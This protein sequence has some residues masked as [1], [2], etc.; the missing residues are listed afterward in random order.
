MGEITEKELKSGRYPY[1]KS[2][3]MIGRYGIESRLE[4]FLT[5]KRG[6]KQVEV[7][8][9]GRQLNVIFTRHP[10]PGKDIYLTI[11][12]TL[13]TRAEELLKGKRGAV[14]ALDPQNGEVL[15]IASSPSF[16]PNEFIKGI[17]N[18]RW[19]QLNDARHAPLQNRAISGLYPPGSVFKIVV[20]LAGLQEGVINPNDEILCSGTYVM[21]DTS[22]GCWKKGGH[23]KVSLHRALV[24][25]CDI[26]FYKMGRELGVDRIARYARQF[27]FGK[28][29]GIDLDYE[30]SGLIPDTRW[31]MKR[32]GM[33]WHPGETLSMA[34]GQSYTLVTP[35]QM[36][37]FISSIFNGGILYKPHV[38]KY[39]GN[40]GEIPLTMDYIR[41]YMDIDGDKLGLVKE[42]LIGV[43]N[44]KRGTGRRASIKGVIVAGKTG[45]AQVVA[46]QKDEGKKRQEDVPYEFRDHAWF[47]AVAPADLPRIAV[48]VVVEHGGH[49]GSAAAPIAGELIK[50]WFS[51][52]KV[53]RGFAQR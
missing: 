16:D 18:E 25:S 36:A 40:F 46:I 35:I 22:F 30:A 49:G 26:Y 33:M 10:L 9:V 2:G 39:A 31:K 19:R 6:K 34:I 28:R 17:S 27:G 7:D 13:Q 4:K 37:C 44:E 1:C 47:V 20:A 42:A 11:D 52:E 21:G 41:G 45:T 38:I 51:K 32:F 43:V 50:T 3:D 12:R 24:E 23:G 14:V 48:A 53:Q 8:S 5:G 15:A 29:T